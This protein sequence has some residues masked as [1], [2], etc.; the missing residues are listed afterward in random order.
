[1]VEPLHG[2]LEALDQSLEQGQEL[3]FYQ[4]PHPPSAHRMVATS[5]PLFPLCREQSFCVMHNAGPSWS[6][7]A[8]SH[9]WKREISQGT[10]AAGCLGLLVV[11]GAGHVL[12][13][14]KLSSSMYVPVRF[15]FSVSQ[16]GV[17]IRQSSNHSFCVQQPLVTC[18]SC[19]QCVL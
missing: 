16:S 7:R 17:V 1:M 18:F 2:D 12:G 15:G 8:E 9:T 6:E 14:L 11:S 5:Q 19:G 13:S 4:Q 3:R 10:V